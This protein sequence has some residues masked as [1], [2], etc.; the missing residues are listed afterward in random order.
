MLGLSP[1]VAKEKRK[2]MTQALI[3]KIEAAT[4]LN[5]EA[6]A[7][8]L[9]KP[10][11]KEQGDLAFPCFAL[12]KPWKL[13][14][15]ECATKLKELLELPEDISD[16]NVLG[17][18]LNFNLNRTHLISK[19]LPG[20][21]DPNLAFLKTHTET[22]PVIIE[23]SSPNI[24]KTFHVGHLRT[25]LIGHALVQIYK[26]VGY[27]TIG[28]NHLGDWGTQFGFVWAGCELWGKPEN[29]DVDS[30]VE[31]YRRATNLRKAQE[32]ETVAADDK[33]KPDVNQL[34][35]DYFIKLET[36]DEEATKF[37]QWCLDVSLDYLKALYLRL[38]ITFDHYTGES[39]YRDQL[40]DVENKIRESGILESSK[41]ALGVDCGKKLGFARIFT[42][43]GRS[44]YITRDIATAMYREKTYHPLKILYIVAA[45]QS[46]H[47][48][49]L[50]EIM[51]KMQHPVAE[52]INHVS[53]GFVPGMKT[54]EGGGISL[55]EFLN[56]AKER[57][58][59]A[60]RSE[61]SKRPDGLDEDE[62]AEKVAIGA[63]Y[64]YFLS[65]S[66]I[67]DFQFS[68]K[69]ALNFQGDSGPY[70]QYALARI[71]SIIEKAKAEG[72][73]PQDSF[74]SDNLVE[75]DAYY[76]FCAVNDLQET[77]EKAAQDCEPYYIAQF[78]LEVAK[79]F[80]RSYKQLRVIGAESRELALDRLTLFAA[81]RNVLETGMR[82]IGI[83]A[84]QRM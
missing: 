59:E 18:Y 9:T 36:G 38:G 73:E 35:R 11:K 49:Q 4:P 34:A 50:I 6:I 26:S 25:T 33:G 71:N 78:L 2:I 54:R 72:L 13:S 22:D 63:T 7:K 65:N 8:M 61:V 29:A 51:K 10:P 20:L 39:F 46:L 5:R 14:P 16:S 55:K 70:L 62:I 56:E 1:R 81:T 80:S 75:D 83:P 58:L 43:D 31:V 24:A 44:L 27:K 52:K 12:A 3:T 37:W 47:F 23:Y 68:W 77:V 48:N 45:Q 42:E 41:G 69:E 17:P 66:N 40:E 32:E 60:Y 21:L 67:K 28:I 82:L 74:N 19:N 64:Y 76:L 53:F 57:A 30:L 15:P 79:T 84:I